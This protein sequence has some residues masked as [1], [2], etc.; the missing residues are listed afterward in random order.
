M[1]SWLAISGLRQ[2]LS[3]GL[4]KAAGA[5]R[6]QVV[7]LAA[8]ARYQQRFRPAL[9][10]EI[11]CRAAAAVARGDVT[12]RWRSW[13]ILARTEDLHHYRSVKGRAPFPADRGVACSL[14]AER[15]L[16]GRD[17]SCRA[18]PDRPAQQRRERLLLAG[19][20][21]RAAKREGL[22]GALEDGRT[23]RPDR[24]CA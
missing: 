13:D 12:T 16:T 15:S 7:P 3:G 24:R 9:P 21:E 8:L 14:S 23:P 11:F 17:A 18:R 10:G 19:S 22:R 2:Q 4:R 20:R 5:H 1:G 6:T